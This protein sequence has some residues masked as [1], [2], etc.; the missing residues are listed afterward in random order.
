M[1]FNKGWSIHLPNPME[2]PLPRWCLVDE[3]V[4]QEGHVSST[5]RILAQPEL[6]KTVVSG[7]WQ[8]L[9]HE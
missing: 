3:A 6:W 2:G 8:W 7:E 4:A 1:K 9:M 5:F